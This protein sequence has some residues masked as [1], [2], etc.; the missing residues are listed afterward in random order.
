VLSDVDVDVDVDGRRAVTEWY[1]F[2]DYSP[3]IPLFTILIVASPSSSLHHHPHR[4]I[5][6]IM[7]SRSEEVRA[8]HILIKHQGSRR[9]ASWRDPD[10]S[11]I[12]NR[13]REQAVTTLQGVCRLL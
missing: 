1:D 13:T 3:S 4:C 5:T 9:L 11:E 8:S 6:I 2:R 7:T 12:K 10:G